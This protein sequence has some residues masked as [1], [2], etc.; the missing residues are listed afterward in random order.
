MWYIDVIKL[1]NPLSLGVSANVFLSFW[2]KKIASVENVGP[3]NLRVLPISQWCVCITNR[4]TGLS[5][6]LK[7][8]NLTVAAIQW[9]KTWEISKIYMPT[10]I[11]TQ[12]ILIQVSQSEQLT[13]SRSP[14]IPIL[15]N[16]VSI[17]HE[18]DS[19]W[20]RPNTNR[21]WT[22]TVPGWTEPT[23]ICSLWIEP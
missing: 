14:K 2:K 13:V 15:S 17:Q 9:W 12:G 1:W 5:Y 21:F 22:E 6:V 16:Y 18:S 23:R 3:K 10:Y 11:L 7:T 20:A 8:I 4:R 19:K